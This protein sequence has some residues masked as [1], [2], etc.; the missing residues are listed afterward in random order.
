MM[1]T[2]WIMGRQSVHEALKAGR[3]MEKVLI[4][5]GTGKGVQ[6]LVRMAKERGI[7]VQRAPRNRLDQLVDGGHHQGVLALVSA[8]HYATVDELF[9]RAQS[10]GEPPFFVLLDGIEDPHNLGSILRTAD[11]A[12]VHGVIIPKRRAVGLT[13]VVAKTSAGAIEYVPVAR[14]TNLNRTAE[15]LKDAGVWI[16]GA[17]ASAAHTFD[18][19]DYTVPVALVI[20]NEG[21]GISRLMK[22][23][24]DYLVQ[25][26]MAG[27]VAS[28]NASVAA[29]LMMYE[30]FRMRRR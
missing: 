18:E 4:A 1:N 12:G 22:E 24:C 13:Q 14:V 19:I 25:L 29:G 23:K 8:Y 2:E 27:R 30:V 28:L 21:Q 26:P 3:E 9:E 7:P 20:G 10:R 5:E 11:A 16:V 6:P 17:D 15:E